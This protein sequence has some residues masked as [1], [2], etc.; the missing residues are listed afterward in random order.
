MIMLTGDSRIIDNSSLGFIFETDNNIS[1]EHSTSVR[2][3]FDTSGEA[4]VLAKS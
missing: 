2:K 1:N 4:S 3:V